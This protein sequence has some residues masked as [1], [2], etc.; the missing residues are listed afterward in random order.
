[1]TI[2]TPTV[3]VFCGA[4]AGKDPS[5]VQIAQAL[6][7]SLAEAEMGLVYGGGQVG[8]MGIIAKACLDGGGTVTG[9]I[10]EDLQKREVAYHDLTELVVVDSMHTRKDLM[11]RRS[12]AFVILPGGIGTLDETLEIMTWRQLG[13][14]HKPIF[15]LE[16]SGYWKPLLD[17]LNHVVDSG[18]AKP[19]ILDFLETVPD[20]P[21]LMAKLR[22]L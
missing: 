22:N 9:V 17:L 11:Y 2:S 21:T 19:G 5:H 16:Q 1:M 8:I 20:V 6:G 3:C 15:L 13:F 18:F 12:D 4:S 14:H 10:P 7:T